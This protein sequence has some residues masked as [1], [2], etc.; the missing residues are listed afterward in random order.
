MRPTTTIR[1]P[2]QQ[3]SASEKMLPSLSGLNRPFKT[4]RPNEEQAPSSFDLERL[5]T[6]MLEMIVE[7]VA[8]M[9]CG[10]T[11][12]PAVCSTSKTL[13]GICTNEV[14]WKQKCKEKGWVEP[15]HPK[16]DMRTWFGHYMVNFCG[17]WRGR[18][19]R[20]LEDAAIHGDVQQVAVALASGAEADKYDAPLRYAVGGTDERDKP[21]MVGVV[22][23]LLAYG[24]PPRYAMIQSLEYALRR[25]G[26]RVS[27]KFITV[28]RAKD[29][30]NYIVKPARAVVQIL[31]NYIDRTRYRLDER[32]RL[33]AL[34][35]LNFNEST[36]K[37]LVRSLIK[38]P[39]GAPLSIRLLVEHYP[40]LVRSDYTLVTDYMEDGGYDDY[41]F[42]NY[43][44]TPYVLALNLPNRLWRD[45]RDR[46][47]MIK[48]LLNTGFL[49]KMKLIRT[50]PLLRYV[51]IWAASKSDCEMFDLLIR[52][53]AEWPLMDLRLEERLV[54]LI[55]ENAEESTDG[56]HEGA[57]DSSDESDEEISDQES[58]DRWL[59]PGRRHYWQG[60]PMCD[61]IHHLVTRQFLRERWRGV[62]LFS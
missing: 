36:L 30:F 11:E 51:T 62:E 38:N 15:S 31:L 37:E 55:R 16:N 18:L 49:T 53:G 27:S 43:D 61:I 52:H 58:E 54:A 60:E 22:K 35:K 40:Y 21:D 39:S 45:R 12:A 10:S 19:E 13:Y 14:L 6:S 4:V 47:G 59:I 29:R 46:H 24:P 23:L 33:E 7:M 34:F 20:M 44:K 41:T 42:Q 25:A 56:V 9:S 8:K 32:F 2:S 5:P 1:M 48:T 17:P 26:E 3:H 28:D 50:E 57:H